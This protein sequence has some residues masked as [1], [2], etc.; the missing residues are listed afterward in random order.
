MV[1]VKRIEGGKK[2]QARGDVEMSGE[3]MMETTAEQWSLYCS[4]SPLGE[5]LLSI[6][7]SLHSIHIT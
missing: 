3:T 4:L 2:V 6:P 7:V 1:S 5:N